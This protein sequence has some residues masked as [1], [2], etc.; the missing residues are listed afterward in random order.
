MSQSGSKKCTVRGA[1]T[2]LTYILGIIAPSPHHLASCAVRGEGNLNPHLP[3]H[4]QKH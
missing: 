1:A 2:D 4:E 3:T